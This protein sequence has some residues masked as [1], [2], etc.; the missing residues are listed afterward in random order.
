MKKIISL[1]AAIALML[2]MAACATDKNDKN[3]DNNDGSEDKVV[4]DDNGTSDDK[5]DDAADNAGNA[6]SDAADNPTSGTT[7]E[8]FG[9]VLKNDFIETVN[10]NPDMTALE[11]ASELITNPVILFAPASSPVEEGYLPGFTSDITGFEEAATF[12]P[13]IGSIPFV[14]YIFTLGEDADVD[15]FM[16]N[17]EANANLRWNV[18]VEAEEMIVDNIG[19]TVFFIMCPESNEG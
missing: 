16:D 8:T 10:E 5:I 11:I 13:I 2:S 1:V 19:N 7:D 15:A 9:T 18:C 12:G 14:G 3:G 6:D 17:L 4:T